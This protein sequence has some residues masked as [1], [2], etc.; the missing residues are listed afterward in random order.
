MNQKHMD[1]ISLGIPKCFKTEGERT[2]LEAQRAVW[3]ALP[4]TDISS[5]R[6]A[7]ELALS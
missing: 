5:S 3:R 7:A 4:V 6:E 1:Y 2:W